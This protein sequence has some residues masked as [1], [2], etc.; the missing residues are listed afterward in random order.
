MEG[1]VVHEET[2]LFVQVEENFHDLQEDSVLDVHAILSV[3]LHHEVFVFGVD[4]LQHGL[5][6]E[7]LAR[8]VQNHIEDLTDLLQELCQVGPNVNEDFVLGP[9]L[10]AVLVK[11]LFGAVNQGL[12]EVQKQVALLL[13]FVFD[14]RQVDLVGE[15]SLHVVHAE[16]FQKSHLLEAFFD[17]GN[18]LLL[19]LVENLLKGELVESLLELHH[20]VGLADEGE[21]GDGF[22][23]P[24]VQDLVSNENFGSNLG[25]LLFCLFFLL[26]GRILFHRVLSGDRGKFVGSDD[27][28]LTELVQ[29]SLV[30]DGIPL[31][32][33]LR[34]FLRGLR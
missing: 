24:I 23:R 29:Q 2:L 20:V 14:V 1:G 10:E 19:V 34:V 5:G 9:Q 31:R 8:G 17:V 11:R 22:L 28:L 25:L 33:R 16:L 12:V 4:D 3:E 32:L 7:A 6:I 26:D 21:F 27:D 18:Y 13:D 30:G 15:N